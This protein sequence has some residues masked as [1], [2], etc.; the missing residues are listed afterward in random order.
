MPGDLTLMEL[1]HG[2]CPD[3]DQW[4]WVQGWRFAL[5]EYIYF[6]CHR[7][8]LVPEFR[9]SAWY[10]P[11]TDVWEFIELTNRGPFTE[12]ELIRVWRVLNRYVNWLKVAG[13]EY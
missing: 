2:D 7:P 13:K 12:D 3:Y 10:E 1:I 9:P 11:D 6:G 4:G 8:D 5:A